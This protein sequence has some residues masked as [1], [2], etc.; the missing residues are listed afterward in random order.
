MTSGSKSRNGY[1]W[2]RKL[3][4]SQE[5]AYLVKPSEVKGVDLKNKFK[6]VTTIF[7]ARIIPL[8]PRIETAEGFIHWK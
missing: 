2:I 3:Q 8:R 1:L 4:K 6:A 5:K 7:S